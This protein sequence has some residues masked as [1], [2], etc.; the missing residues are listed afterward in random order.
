MFSTTFSLVTISFSDYRKK[1]KGVK[2]LKT[3]I[4]IFFHGLKMIFSGESKNRKKFDFSQGAPPL[5]FGSTSGDFSFFCTF[6]IFFFLEA[7]EKVLDV[8]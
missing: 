2:K 7:L 6:L 1:K 3:E 5:V 4:M 8:P